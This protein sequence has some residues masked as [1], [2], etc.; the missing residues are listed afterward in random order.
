MSVA[1][2]D[3]QIERRAV[4][5]GEGGGAATLGGWPLSEKRKG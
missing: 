5:G 4:H 2:G 3:V 1:D